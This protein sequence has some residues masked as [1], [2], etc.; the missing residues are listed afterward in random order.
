MSGPPSS[1]SGDA[2]REGP[3]GDVVLEDRCRAGVDLEAA[4]AR[5]LARSF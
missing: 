4:V 2:A 5:A 1:E 3:L